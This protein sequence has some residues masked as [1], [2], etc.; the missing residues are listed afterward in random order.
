MSAI[1][2]YNYL[3]IEELMLPSQGV[4]KWAADGADWADHRRLLSEALCEHPLRP[5]RSA[6]YSATLAGLR[7]CHPNQCSITSIATAFC[8]VWHPL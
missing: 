4:R 6:V 5:R 7:N 3:P 8:G 2:L 1:G